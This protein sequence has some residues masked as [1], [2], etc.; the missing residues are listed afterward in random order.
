MVDK[1]MV[2]DEE[3]LFALADFVWQVTR[4]QPKSGKSDGGR[5]LPTHSSEQ[6]KAGLF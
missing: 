6:V 3:I 5:I 1:W 4:I 2:G